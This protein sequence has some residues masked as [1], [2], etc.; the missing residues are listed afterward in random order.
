MILLERLAP[1]L[2]YGIIAGLCGLG[3]ATAL[4][5]A[6]DAKF[7]KAFVTYWKRELL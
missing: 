1:L 3:A 5:L 6:T 2:G 7:R 4:M